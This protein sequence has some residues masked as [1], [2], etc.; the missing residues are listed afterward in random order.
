VIGLMAMLAPY[1]VGDTEVA[2]EARAKT[3]QT[4]YRQL[5]PEGL[6]PEVFRGRGAY[7]DYFAGQVAV[8]GGF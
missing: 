6:D 7:G 3:F 2:W 8:V 1:L 5:L 4:R